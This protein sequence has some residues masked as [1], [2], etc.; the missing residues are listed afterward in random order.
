[1]LALAQEKKL[2]LR[3][4]SLWRGIARVAEAKRLRDVFP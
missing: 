3:T 1:V 4:A 2:D